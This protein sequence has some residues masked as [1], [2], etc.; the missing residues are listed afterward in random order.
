MRVSDAERDAA[1]AELSLHFQSGRITQE[2]FDER[3]G[4]ALQAKTGDDLRKLFTDLPSHEPAGLT[5]VTADR[6][7]KPERTGGGLKRAGGRRGG[8]T[9]IVIA[10]VIASIVIGN[11]AGMMSQGFHHASVGWLVP[12]VIL[13]IALRRISR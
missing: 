6:D 11:V 10:C 4:L 7:E 5:A 8:A 13:L 2:E 1:L 9:R 12:V 3:S